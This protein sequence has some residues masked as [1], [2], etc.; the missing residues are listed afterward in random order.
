[1]KLRSST[2]T[3]IITLRWD[4]YRKRNVVE[5]FPLSVICGMV[6]LTLSLSTLYDYSLYKK[7]SNE[8][9]SLG[10]QVIEEQIDTTD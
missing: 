10:L 5:R 1:M 4:E 8:P 9:L 7:A 2:P 6:A 3:P